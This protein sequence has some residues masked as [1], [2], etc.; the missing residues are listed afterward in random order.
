MTRS[1]FLRTDRLVAF[2]SDAQHVTDPV[3][4][5]ATLLEPDPVSPGAT[6]LEPDPVS[7][8]ATLLEPAYTP[9]DPQPT[10]LCVSTGFNSAH[11]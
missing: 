6:L 11:L 4:Q 2:P 5:G 7:Q 9:A 3:S 10:P 8:G 1:V